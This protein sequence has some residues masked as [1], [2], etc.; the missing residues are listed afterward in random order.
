MQLKIYDISMPVVHLIHLTTE[1]TK[2]LQYI[3]NKDIIS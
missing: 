1:M 3:Y 2:S